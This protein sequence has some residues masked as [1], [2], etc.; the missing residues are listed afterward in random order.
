MTEESATILEK[1]RV[2]QV[3]VNTVRDVKE[4][5]IFLGE[6]PVMGPTGTFMI[7]GVERVIVSQMHRS[8]V[9]FFSHDKG[10]SHVSGKILYSARIIPDRGSWIAF[11]FDIKDLL[12]V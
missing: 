10:K 3:T 6:M 9:A 7:N 11:E 8:P 12:Y 2:S 1:E 5:K 4:Q